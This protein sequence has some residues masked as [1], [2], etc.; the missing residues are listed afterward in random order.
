MK[1]VAQTLSIAIGIGLLGLAHG[2]VGPADM[3]VNSGLSGVDTPPGT[4]TLAI[5]ATPQVMAH[6]GHDQ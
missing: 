1:A 4:L 5:A 3:Q 6:A 2:Q